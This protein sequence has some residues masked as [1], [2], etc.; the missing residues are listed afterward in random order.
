M[1]G[2]PRGDCLVFR[3]KD[4]DCPDFCLSKN[5]TVPFAHLVQMRL[6]DF[7]DEVARSTPAPGGGSIAALAGSLGAALG[8]MVANLAQ[9]KTADGPLRQRLAALTEQAEQI[10]DQLLRAVDE[11][12]AAFDAYLQA[13]RRRGLS[14]FSH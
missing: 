14:Q 8:R 13:L 4:G 1:I 6:C 11:D 12:A 2:L 3:H 7:A 9:H 10:K 5:G